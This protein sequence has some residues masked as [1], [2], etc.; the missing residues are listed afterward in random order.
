MG[1]ASNICLSCM[2]CCNGTTIGYVQLEER[3]IL[4]VRDIL[5][6]EEEDGNGF[7][8]QPCKKLGCNG[9][10]VYNKRPKQ[11]VKFECKLLLS[12][13]D[14]E[15]TIPSAV[16]IVD[17]VKK[18]KQ[19]IEGMIQKENINLKS[20]SFYFKAFELRKNLKK[21]PYPSEE[22]ENLITELEELNL[23]VTKN[24]GISF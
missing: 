13:K 9:C 1:D 14:K 11:C 8:L 17:E 3:E 23:I 2:L 4:R 7:F 6:I 5:E 10:T 21:T 19:I 20:K 18:K 16:L 12:I 24:F 15:I 22:L